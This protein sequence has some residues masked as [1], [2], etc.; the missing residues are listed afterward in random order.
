MEQKSK[1]KR[2]AV[3]KPKKGRKLTYDEKLANAEKIITQK[4][5]N[6]KGPDLFEKII[7]KAVSTRSGL[8]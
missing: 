5:L 7:K 3:L 8:K 2:I 6:S 4:E 1:H